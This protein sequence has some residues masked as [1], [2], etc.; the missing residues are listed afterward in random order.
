[1]T[2]TSVPKVIAQGIQVLNIKALSV[3]D[4]KLWLMFTF[5]VREQTKSSTNR[6]DKYLYYYLSI[7]GQK[8]ASSPHFLH[9]QEH[10]IKFI[11]YLFFM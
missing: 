8:Y 7:R 10:S 4:K 11:L 1:M 9:V 6:Q 2:M 3:A 5:F